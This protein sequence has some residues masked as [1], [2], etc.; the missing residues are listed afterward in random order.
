MVPDP[1]RQDGLQLFYSFL[2]VMKLLDPELRLSDTEREQSL[3]RIVAILDN[4][5]FSERATLTEVPRM[6]TRDKNDEVQIIHRLPLP[7]S[8]SLQPRFRSGL[9]GL[10]V[11]IAFPTPKAFSKGMRQLGL[12]QFKQRHFLTHYVLCNNRERQAGQVPQNLKS[13]LP[14]RVG[15]RHTLRKFYPLLRLTAGRVLQA[16]SGNQFT[17]NRRCLSRVWRAGLVAARCLV[18]IDDQAMN[19][20]Q[21]SHG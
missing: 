20:A 1:W 13:Q 3:R 15:P 17:Q 7:V 14:T 6:E 9:P 4:Y 12:K 8:I 16:S 18:A 5:I 10:A 11:T 19:Q 2:I 21:L